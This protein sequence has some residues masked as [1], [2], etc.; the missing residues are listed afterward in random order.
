MIKDI[1]R[2][3]VDPLARARQNIGFDNNP[4]VL[5]FAGFT[6]RTFFLNSLKKRRETIDAN[7]RHAASRKDPLN[8]ISK[9]SRP[10]KPTSGPK[11]AAMIPLLINIAAAV[12]CCFSATASIATNRI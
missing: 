12:A 3:E 5:I 7:T 1:T 4:L 10:K 11:N 8:S 6:S 9:R 2:Y